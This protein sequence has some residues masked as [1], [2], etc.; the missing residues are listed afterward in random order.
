M[1]R[2]RKQYFKELLSKKQFWLFPIVAVTWNESVYYMGKILAKNKYH[3]SF[4]LP[5]DEQIPLVSWTISIYVICFL[6]WAIVYL[7][8]SSREKR[9]ALRFYLA[10]FLGKLTCLPFFVFLPTTM[11]R[12][13][14]I[15]KGFWE[16]C[17]RF[18]Y[19]VDAADNLFPS[20]H[21]MVSWFCWIGLRNQK[22]CPW[23]WRYGALLFAIAVCV[24]T[25]TTRQH[26]VIDIVGGIGFA[27]LAYL[28]AGFLTPY[29][30]IKNNQ[31]E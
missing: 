10:D 4:A 11:E 27:E 29:L 19:Q 17:M 3:Y 20:I 25:V 30:D 22:Q 13:E 9:T 16:V 5:I 2:S 14:I 6:I 21:C 1:D 7:Y 8:M 31:I 18:L 12:P 26:V 15:E 24:S 28:L 23:W